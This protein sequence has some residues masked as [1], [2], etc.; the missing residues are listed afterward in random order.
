M[1][2]GILLVLQEK[3]NHRDDENPG[4]LL[5]FTDPLLRI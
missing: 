3:F 1:I 2:H 4:E 5:S